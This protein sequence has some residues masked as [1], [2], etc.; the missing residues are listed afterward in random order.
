[1]AR[2]ERQAKELDD[3]HDIFERSRVK[4]GV[5]PELLHAV[6]AKAMS[7]AGTSL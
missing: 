4:V 3:L 6:V 2:R 1:M 5:D 7:R